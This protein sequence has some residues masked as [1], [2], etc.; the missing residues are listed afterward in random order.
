LARVPAGLGTENHRGGFSKIHHVSVGTSD[1]ARA[2]AF[3]DAVL[4]VVGLA[5]MKAGDKGA[6]CG[7]GQLV[8]S[9]ETPVN[10]E[11]VAVGN[12]SHVAFAAEDRAMMDRF[13]ETALLRDGARQWRNE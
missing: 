10:W 12:G 1:V 13:Y 11:P 3:Y 6:D 4:P 9:V 7:S 5:L 8:F 2:R